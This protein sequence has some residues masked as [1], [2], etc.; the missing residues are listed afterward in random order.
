MLKDF[1]QFVETKVSLNTENLIG[2]SNEIEKSMAHTSLASSKMIRAGGLA[3][4]KTDLAGLR[5]CPAA[6]RQGVPGLTGH[7]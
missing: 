7:P 1:L 6:S 2:N 5:G 3:W 4:R